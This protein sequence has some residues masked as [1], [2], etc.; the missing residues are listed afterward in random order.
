MA[1]QL[2]FEGFLKRQEIAQEL[3]ISEQTLY[4]WMKDEDFTSAYDDY[5]KVIMSKS[6]GKH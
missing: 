6:S 3:K 4:N 2:L 5:V 1:I